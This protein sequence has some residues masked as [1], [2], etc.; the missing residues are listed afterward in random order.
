ML[1]QGAVAVA[2]QPR[3]F[4]PVSP[5]PKAP[6]LVQIAHEDSQADWGCFTARALW[7]LDGKAFKT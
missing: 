6:P 5:W 4:R 3:W 7:P 2:Q 1:S